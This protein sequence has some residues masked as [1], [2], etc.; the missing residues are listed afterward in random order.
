MQLEIEALENNGTWT[1][2]KFPPNK[3]AIDKKMG[4]LN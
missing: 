4:I 3:K 1:I 2:Q